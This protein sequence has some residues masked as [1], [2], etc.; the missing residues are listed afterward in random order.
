ME[1]NQVVYYHSFSGKDNTEERVEKM[2]NRQNISDNRTSQLSWK[3][4]L[5][6]TLTTVF[7]FVFAK[8]YG[9]FSHGVS[10]AFMSY[11]FLLPLTLIFL[12]KFINLCTGNRLWNLSLENADEAGEKKLFFASLASFLWKSGV[13]V[14]TVGSIYKGVL[15]IYG[16]SGTF[17][18]IYLVVGILALVSGGIGALLAKKE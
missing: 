2:E 3:S 11:A 18:W 4:L 7:V 16:T 13:A 14:L 8:I 17:E 10:S 12:P 5:P 9:I 1:K 6:I 15:D